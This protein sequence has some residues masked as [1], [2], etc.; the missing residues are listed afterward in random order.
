LY[1]GEVEIVNND[2]EHGS[3]EQTGRA[4]LKKGYHKIRVVYFDSGGGNEL[5][6]FWQLGTGP[7][8]IIPG[9]ILFH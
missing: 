3:V 8:E 2:E 5:K 7:K 1:I 6:V 4:P 9:N